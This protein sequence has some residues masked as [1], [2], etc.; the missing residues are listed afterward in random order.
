ME[1]PG[2]ETQWPILNPLT[3][4]IFFPPNILVA[5]LAA[6]YLV[7]GVTGM[8][9]WDMLSHVGMD[10]RLLF[11]YRV[12][13]PTFVYFLSRISTMAYLIVQTIFVTA[14]LPDCNK[15]VFAQLG[16]YFVAAASTSFL[17]FLRI[18]AIYNGARFVIIVYSL[19][20]LL[21]LGCYILTFFTV[22]G[23]N[24]GISAKLY[25]SHNI[26]VNA[27]TTTERRSWRNGF[28]IVRD[29]KQFFSGNN[30]PR[31]SRTLLKDG[32]VYYLV[33][34]L[35]TALIILLNFT[36]SPAPAFHLMTITP[37]IALAN[38]MAGY[39]YR[40][41]RFG[42]IREGELS[43]AIGSVPVS[44][45][46][47]LPDFRVPGFGGVGSH[48]NGRSG[49]GTAGSDIGTHG[50]GNVNRNGS[51]HGHGHGHDSGYGSPYVG[52]AIG[53]ARTRSRSGSMG[54]RY[55]GTYAAGRHP[56][57]ASSLP[58]KVSFSDSIPDFVVR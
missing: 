19:L 35:T 47:S 24:I 15:A 10:W 45:N 8:F 34:F 33:V 16:C 11:E 42:I 29:V 13:L 4:D 20:W 58:R 49:S 26:S 43:N 17:F 21:N 57:Q 18:R 2:N 5:A 22:G 6:T 48:V 36:P 32:Q 41:V 23:M 55:T 44:I 1:S 31:L 27:G 52:S 3:P 40:N 14:P 39:V 7:V 28:A 56:I 53:H 30:L 54:T 12:G 38:S 9:L 37:H 51:N 25:T 50:N 46:P